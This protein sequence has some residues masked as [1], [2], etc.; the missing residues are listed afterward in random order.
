VATVKLSE[1]LEEQ[2]MDPAALKEME[3]AGLTADSRE[4]KPGYL[5]AALPGAKADGRAFVA[6]AV[7]RG[8]AAVLAPPGTELG[9]ARADTH[10]QV[11]RLITDSNPRR[12]FAL[13]AAKFYPH[14]PDV[15]AAV[16]GTNGKTSVA[17]FAQQLWTALGKR[18]GYMGTLGAWGGNKKI[19]G[20]LTTPDPVGVHRVLEDLSRAGV[21]H[22]AMEAS[23]HGLHQFR[24]D[25]V[26]VSIAGFTNLSRDHLDYHGSM[27]AY[28]AAKMRLFSDVL[29]EGGT[30]VLNADTPEF[31]ALDAA[32]R[33]RRHRVLSYGERGDAIRLDDVTRAAASQKLKLSIF[34]Q[35]YDVNLPL[36]GRFQVSNALCALGFVL[37]GGAEPKAAFA[38]LEKLKG[39]PGRLEHVGSTTQNAPVYVDYA[40]T[41]DALE[42]VL[43]ALRPHATGKLVVVFGCGGDRDKGKRRLMGEKAKELADRVI[44]T[45][46]NPRT[47]VPATIRREILQGCPDSEEIGDRDLAIKAAVGGLNAGDVLLIAGKGHESGQIVG[48]TVIPF[49]DAEVARRHLSGGRS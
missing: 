30:A 12:R 18:S 11:I 42:T 47:E 5:F 25:G 2:G 23:S 36:A 13:M 17:H 44:V 7:S 43:N 26:R 1:L 32:C 39:V 34:G 41:P 24:V 37:A 10:G 40:H 19:D 31:P 33:L 35:R 48:A 14:Q 20:S 45:D 27:A 28:L 21:T 46:D 22:L 49:S 6:E 3:I 15:V 16:T 38:A 8:A 4:V 9:A 29:T